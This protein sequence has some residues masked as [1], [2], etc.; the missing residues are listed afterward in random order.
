MTVWAVQTDWSL[1]GKE[2]SSDLY[3]YATEEL[4]K[5]SFAELVAQDKTE[6]YADVYCGESASDGWSWEEDNNYWC[7]YKNDDYCE[8]HSE[9]KIEQYEVINE[10]EFERLR[11]R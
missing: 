11:G 1:N 3:L 9:I 7:I 8:N 10:D 4:A 2:C 5:K 6:N